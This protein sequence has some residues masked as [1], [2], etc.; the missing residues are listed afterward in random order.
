MTDA[1]NA[2][3]NYAT[4]RHLGLGWMAALR[5]DD[6]LIVANKDSGERIDVPAHA[7]AKLRQIFREVGEA[8][9]A[10]AA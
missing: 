5:T 1:A 6:S 7:V 3:I 8:K 9:P 4:F 10:I 2:T